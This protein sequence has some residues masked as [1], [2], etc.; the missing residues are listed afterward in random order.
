M[1]RVVSASQ[2]SVVR[3][4]VRRVCAANHI[5]HDRCDDAQLAASEL[6]GNALRH[7]AEP[8]EVDVTCRD[9]GILVVVSDAQPALPQPREVTP[10]TA[11]S[12]RGMFL[13][14]AVSRSWGCERTTLGKRVWAL[15]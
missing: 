8:V 14:E 7:G 10:Q 3:A 11:E 13:V 15:V 4:C 9:G 1:T 12:G 5:D 6:V 2:V